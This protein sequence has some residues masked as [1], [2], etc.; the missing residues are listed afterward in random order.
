MPVLSKFRIKSPFDEFENYLGEEMN[1]FSGFFKENYVEEDLIEETK[2]EIPEKIEEKIVT[3]S[4]W[5][6][7]IHSIFKFSSELFL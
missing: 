7:M 1:T 3:K 4:L 5:Q 2:D 6:R